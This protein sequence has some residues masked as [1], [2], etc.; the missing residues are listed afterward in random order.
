MP[1]RGSDG[2]Q[3][4][5]LIQSGVFGCEI[6][7]LFN[8]HSTPCRHVCCETSPAWECPKESELKAWERVEICLWPEEARRGGIIHPGGPD[9][10]PLSELCRE[11]A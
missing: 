8:R 11:G 5:P 9:L 3:S 7:Q 1:R 6:S 4:E 10:F 2:P